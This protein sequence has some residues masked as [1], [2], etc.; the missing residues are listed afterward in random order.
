MR[1]KENP[2]IGNITEID[3]K[4]YYRPVLSPERAPHF[5]IC[6]FSDGGKKR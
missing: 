5:G 3:C 2:V 1:Q 6:K 4:A